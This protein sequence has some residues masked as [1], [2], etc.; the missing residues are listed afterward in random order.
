MVAELLRL[1][2]SVFVADKQGRTPLHLAAMSGSEP[3][4]DS[5]IAAGAP[6]TSRDGDGLTPRE[7]AQP[8]RQTRQRQERLLDKL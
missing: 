4:V 8:G 5:L 2:A 3:A 6:R 1:N 7:L